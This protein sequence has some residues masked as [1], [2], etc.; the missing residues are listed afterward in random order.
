MSFVLFDALKQC[1]VDD[2]RAAK[3]ENACDML[4]VSEQGRKRVAQAV[5]KGAVDSDEL[6]ALIEY[7]PGLVVTPGAVSRQPMPMLWDTLVTHFQLELS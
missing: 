3:I 2:T 6:L 1:G 5:A 7:A 4:R